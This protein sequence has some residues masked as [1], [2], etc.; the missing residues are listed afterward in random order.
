MA[1]EDLELKY[2]REHVHKA[3]LKA[4]EKM[5]VEYT[6]VLNNMMVWVSEDKSIINDILRGEGISSNK[7]VMTNFTD[8]IAQ[9]LQGDKVS[10]INWLIAF[11]QVII[12]GNE[13]S[14]WKLSLPEI[15]SL[16]KREQ[17]RLNPKRF[18]LREKGSVWKG[19]LFNSIKENLDLTNDAL[20][21]RLILSAMINSGLLNK[22]LIFAF[23]KSLKSPLKIF[24]G[25]AFYDLSPSWSGHED[26]E[27]RR[28]FPHNL[29]EILIWNIQKELWISDYT[30]EKMSGSK[31]KRLVSKFLKEAGVEKDF[32]PNTVFELFDAV[33]VSADLFMPAFLVDYAKR[34]YFSHSLRQSA[35]DRMAGKKPIEDVKKLAEKIDLAHRSSQPRITEEEDLNED[36]VPWQFSWSSPLKNVV[37]SSTVGGAISELKIFRDSNDF[38]PRSVQM[39]LAGWALS[40]LKPSGEEKTIKP[41]SVKGYISVVG[42]RL[43]EVFHTID[44]DDLTAED[45]GDAYTL[46]LDDIESKGLRRKV[47]K[48]LYLF[49]RYL[50]ITHHAEPI[51]YNSILGAFSAPTPVDANIIYIEEY[52]RMLSALDHSNLILIH[53]KLVEIVR[54]VMI[55]GYRCGLRRSEALKLRLIDIQGS[56][57][58]MLLIRP[59]S[60]R[61][62]KTSSSKRQILLKA[63]L[64]EDEYLLLLNWKKKRLEEEGKSGYSE[65]LFSIPEKKY[66]CVSEDIVFPAIHAAMRAVTKDQSLRYHHFRHSFAS[67]TFL[68]LMAT[69]YGLPTKILDGVPETKK[70][71]L[72]GDSFVKEIYGVEGFTRKHTYLVAKLLGH[73]G[74]SVSLEHYIHIL[75]ILLHG[76]YSKEVHVP[77]SV[78]IKASGLAESTSYRWMKKGVDFFIEN[79]RRKLGCKYVQNRDTKISITDIR[80]DLKV[81]NFGFYKIIGKI[82]EILFLYSAYNYSL[83]KLAHRHN[84]TIFEIQTIINNAINLFEIK[85]R[86]TLSGYKYKK[87]LYAMGNE[88]KELLCPHPP[89][90]KSDI[91][92]AEVFSSGFN[93]CKINNKNTYVEILGL[94]NLYS[95]RTR[96]WIVLRNEKD[97][98]KILSFLSNM[99]LSP[100]E[101]ELSVLHGQKEISSKIRRNLNTWKKELPIAKKMVWKT[102]SSTDGR[103]MGEKGWL[104]INIINRV[105]NESTPAIRY[106]SVMTLIMEGALE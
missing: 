92:L 59:H 82:W 65:Y 72:G 74:P 101:I 1:I 61:G 41:I 54:M 4:S 12:I 68:R 76:F 69:D 80:D 60:G 67:L 36:E 48:V 66:G 87:M 43:S 45:F 40:L 77:D 29:T 103:S 35:W 22:Q 10:L 8:D 7:I 52:R 11:R 23:M 93:D 24:Q 56:Y 3:W 90:R 96:Y 84:K 14:L 86:G 28:W 105:S 88:K 37:T 20:L 79:T 51:D 106:I 57:D 6:S 94:Y 25:K 32:Q 102:A 98:N 33:S 38:H 9:Y 73:S 78:L 89:R 70:W 5:G 53:P 2:V 39:L 21:G 104:G 55:L 30:S 42:R 97:A 81:I 83:E 62:L 16:A 71:V 47:S 50:E 17:G 26:I 63:F 27:F 34:K 95:W 46:I 75:D 85:T 99:E 19:A 58:A 15:P 91:N 100:E 44:C 18:T 64:E 13:L 49:H 31:I